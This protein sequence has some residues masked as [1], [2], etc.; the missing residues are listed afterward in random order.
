M[1][2]FVLVDSLQHYMGQM[3]P[4]VL[5]DALLSFGNVLIVTNIRVSSTTE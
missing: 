3:R 5:Y 2:H 1:R 4:I